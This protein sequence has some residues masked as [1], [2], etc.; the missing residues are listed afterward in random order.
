[1]SGISCLKW[2][3]SSLPT[4][5]SRSKRPRYQGLYDTA[6][7]RL[8]ESRAANL[9]LDLIRVEGKAD[10]AVMVGGS[11]RQDAF[12]QYSEGDTLTE[13]D[14][15][16][17]APFADSL[18]KI[19]ISLMQ[20]LAFAEFGASLLNE[21]A[22]STKILHVSG[23]SVVYDKDGAVEIKYDG[24]CH[25]AG[26][27]DRRASTGRCG[28]TLWKKDEIP[29]D[30]DPLE[31]FSLSGITYHLFGISEANPLRAS[32]DLAMTESQCA[33]AQ[34]RGETDV[35]VYSKYLAWDAGFPCEDG[36]VHPSYYEHL[37]QKLPW[38]K[39]SIVTGGEASNS[40]CWA[41]LAQLT[42]ASGGA[43][44]GKTR[45][46]LTWLSDPELAKYKIDDSHLLWEVA[47]AQGSSAAR[48]VAAA[49]SLEGWAV[50]KDIETESEMLRRG[51]R[52]EELPLVPEDTLPV[53]RWLDQSNANT[54]K[55]M[56]T[57]MNVLKP[58]AIDHTDIGSLGK[59][60]GAL[61]TTLTDEEDKPLH[62]SDNVQ[63]NVEGLKALVAEMQHRVKALS[64]QLKEPGAASSLLDSSAEALAA[65]LRQRAGVL[66]RLAL[67]HARGYR[68]DED[69]R[70]W[71]HDVESYCPATL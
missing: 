35:V 16:E 9:L 25:I 51:V 20:L 37:N 52:A 19:E 41:L 33:I 2:S 69:G 21:G 43:A 10:F 65:E 60:I 11:I 6:N 4:A 24:D 55:K 49:N 59:L 47:H 17:E 70:V 61:E 44:E 22:I 64:E 13:L 31:K 18:A 34:E 40:N 27:T 38:T 42:K 3:T 26:A 67:W 23:F 58:G 63:L 28:R 32:G 12:T 53:P 46:V 68:A 66:C 29:A 56:V 1:M 62:V 15:Y 54:Q 71:H 5:F 48:L 14:L 36:M 39:C 8:R 7:V 50:S 30:V 45:K 57:L